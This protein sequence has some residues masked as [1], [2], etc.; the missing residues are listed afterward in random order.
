MSLMNVELILLVVLP[1]LIAVL[2]YFSTDFN[3]RARNSIAVTGVGIE[4][5]LVL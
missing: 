5:L 2:M 1:S 4:L 3:Q